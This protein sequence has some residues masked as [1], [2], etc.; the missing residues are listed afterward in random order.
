VPLKSFLETQVLPVCGF[1]LIRR[2]LEIRPA[3]E[4]ILSTHAEP[5]GMLNTILATLAKLGRDVVVFY[6]SIARPKA[7]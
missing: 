3:V 5:L 1:R 4:N 6:F 2:C 7:F